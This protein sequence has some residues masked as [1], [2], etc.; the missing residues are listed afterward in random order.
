LLPDFLITKGVFEMKKIIIALII[1][2]IIS[3]TANAATAFWTGQMRPGQSVTGAYVFNCQY[4]YAGNFFWRAYS[5][6]CPYSIEVN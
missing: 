2:L 1:G 3:G 6:S 4:Q 5:G